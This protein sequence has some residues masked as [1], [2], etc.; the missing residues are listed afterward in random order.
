MNGA[1]VGPIVLLVMCLCLPALI[2]AALR[3]RPRRRRGSA[4]WRRRRRRSD[5]I[6]VSDALRAARRGR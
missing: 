6:D 5:R 1:V 3:R 2:A 4:L